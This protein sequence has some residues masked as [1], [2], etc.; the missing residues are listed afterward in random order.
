MFI[1][2][3]NNMSIKDTET[4]LGGAGIAFLGLIFIASTSNINYIYICGLL[5][6]FSIMCLLMCRV[7][8][9]R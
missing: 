8:Q 7:S 3:G 6:M 4:Y 2:G 5:T 9:V 1:R